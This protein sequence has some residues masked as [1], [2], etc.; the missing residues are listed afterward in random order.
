MARDKV[1]W[2]VGYDK[3]DDFLDRAVAVGATGVAIR[4]DNDLGKAITGGHA[5]SLK[6]YG[7]RWPAARHDSAMAEAARIVGFLGEGLDGY[8]VDP[9][10]HDA[11][12][13]GL[14]W[15]QPGLSPLADKFCRA[16]VAAGPGKAFGTTSHYLAKAT[17]P[18]LPWESFFKYSTVLLPQ[19]YWRTT[20]GPVGHARPAENYAKSRTAWTAAGGDAAKVEPMAGELGVS[21][22]AD[23]VAYA[24]AATDAGASALHFYAYGGE[25][26]DDVWHAVRND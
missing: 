19:A 10:S 17:A 6:V 8:F 26:K 23:I 9:E 16:I 20:E 7:W 21:K 18:N 24:Q 1:L 5:R 14:N 4:S 22:V 25:V 13:P 3:L 2:V 11:T 12:A 15:N